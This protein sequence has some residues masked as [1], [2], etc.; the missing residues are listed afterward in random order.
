MRQSHQ[1]LVWTMDPVRLP[2]CT[3]GALMLPE[4]DP[5]VVSVPAGHESKRLFLISA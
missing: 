1:D 3:V 4:E 5:R 2:S